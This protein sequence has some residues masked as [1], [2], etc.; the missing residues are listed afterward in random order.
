MKI[1]FTSSVSLC[2]CANF[3]EDWT[4]TLV[5]VPKWV[6][7]CVVERAPFKLLTY[8][9]KWFPTSELL[10]MEFGDAKKCPNFFIHP[11]LLY[12]FFFIYVIMF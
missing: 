3:G 8:S 9:G 5:V 4:K 11:V 12:A 2:L 10:Q 6:Q 1:L 7:S